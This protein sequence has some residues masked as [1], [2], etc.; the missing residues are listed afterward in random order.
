M[1]SNVFIQWLKHYST[2]KVGGHALLGIDAAASHLDIFIAKSSD[3]LIVALLCCP[4]IPHTSF[5]HQT[6]ASLGASN[7]IE[8][9]SCN[10][11]GKFSKQE[12]SSS[13]I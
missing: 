10:I 13:G 12:N 11:I 8:M 5:N 9:K 3:K 4:I 1:T 7:I 2:Y 6:N